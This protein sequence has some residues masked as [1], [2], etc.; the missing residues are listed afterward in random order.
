MTDLPLTK[1]SETDKTITLGWEPVGLAAGYVF[2]AGGKRVSN[3]WDTS[4]TWAKFAKPGPWSVQAVGVLASGVYPPVVT[5]PDQPASS[6][7]APPVPP[8]TTVTNASGLGRNYTGM[9][10]AQDLVIDGTGDTAVLFQPGAANSVLRRARLLRCCIGNSVSYG[11][12]AIYAKARDLTIEDVYAECAS[13]A[14]SGFSL[15][16]DGA[17]LRRSEVHG[18]PHALTYYETSKVAGAVLVEDVRG[19]FRGDTG[20][21]AALDSE[22]RVLQAFTFRRVH[23][24]GQGEF[25]KA[26]AF[27][28]SVRVEACTLNGRPVTASDLPGVP[29]VVVA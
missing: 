19:S 17:V 16:Y 27:A 13:P 5:P 14:A 2:F 12:H 15:R 25:M 18:A 22:P 9:V 29:N 7:P 23:L 8:I 24:I 6:W 26:T 3:T 10:T 4:K 20:V 21:W 1:I 11:K 28:G